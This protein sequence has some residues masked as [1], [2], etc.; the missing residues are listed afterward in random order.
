L[1]AGS[2]HFTFK[3]FPDVPRR[4]MDCGKLLKRTEVA[5]VLE[6]PIRGFRCAFCAFNKQYA[7]ALEKITA[8]SKGGSDEPESEHRD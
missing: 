2:Q 4:C 1:T 3:M 6:L 8:M 5:Q 7:E